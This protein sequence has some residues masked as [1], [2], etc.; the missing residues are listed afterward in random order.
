MR[1]DESCD[2]GNWRCRRGLL[3][4]PWFRW[5]PPSPSLQAVRPHHLFHHPHGQALLEAAELA[6]ISSSF[7]HR[8]VLVRQA[9]VLG[10]LLHRPLEESLAALAGADAI[11]LAGSIVPTHSTR[12]A[13]R[14]GLE[15][16]VSKI[17]LRGHLCA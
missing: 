15:V 5:K 1:P 2:Q 4:A 3:V 12:E 9:D 17:G 11:V 7:V 10:V 8:A 16:E 14:G 13:Q 6:A